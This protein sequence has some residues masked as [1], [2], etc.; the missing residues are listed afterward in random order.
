MDN[1][2]TWRLDRAAK[3]GALARSGC[4]GA[5]GKADSAIQ[6]RVKD[7]T[8]HSI[9]MRL[10]KPDPTFSAFNGLSFKVKGDGSDNWACLR[11]QAGGWG[12]AYVAPFPLK[13]T[14]WHEVRLAWGD[15]IPTSGVL[16]D[17][18]SADGHRPGDVN[19]IGFGSSWNFNTRHKSP[20]ITFCVDELKL[21]KGVQA[22]R[23]RVA[24]DKFPGI[25]AVRAK[26]K[27]GETVTVLA[28][29]DSITWGTSAGG[30]A[31]AYPAVVG[32]MLNAKY[33]AGKVKIVSRAIGGSTTA[34]GRQWLMRD[35]KGVQADLVTVMFGY[36]E[37]PGSDVAAATKGYTANLVRYVEEVAGSM[38]R[39]PACVLIAPI[40]GRKT[41]WEKLDAYAEG[42]RR[43]GVKHANVPI[44]DANAHFKKMGQPAYSK[45]M[46]D[47]AHP[48][49]TGQTEMAKAV[50]EAITGEKSGE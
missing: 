47:E 37:K 30:N 22:A 28:L 27:A 40:P 12:K 4:E 34:K 36:N 13:K 45:L 14:D 41:N 46:A 49:P 17:L 33:G 25:A 24:I 35:V 23:P 10:A 16:P 5:A 29:G 11:L 2:D 19:L 38:K 43:L 15:F 48:N 8:R 7:G 44:A 21:I 26:L 39:P 6:I 3:A 9:A 42:V 32:R 20:A 18:G 1:P 50:F 31:N